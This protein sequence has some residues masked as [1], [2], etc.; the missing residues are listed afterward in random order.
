MCHCICVPKK[1][2]KTKRCPECFPNHEKPKGHDP[3][4]RVEQKQ[5]RA[6]GKKLGEILATADELATEPIEGK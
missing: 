6:G 1:S 4:R 2:G 3:K 5:R